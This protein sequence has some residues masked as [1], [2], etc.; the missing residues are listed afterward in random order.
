MNL[1]ELFSDLGNRFIALFNH[2]DE[3]QS[4]EWHRRWKEKDEAK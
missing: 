4:I 2:L 1:D 3:V